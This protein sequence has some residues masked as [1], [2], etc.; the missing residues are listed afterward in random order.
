MVT[1][2]S[3]KKSDCEHYAL[4]DECDDFFK[5]K[6][7]FGKMDIYKCPFPKKKF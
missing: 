7:F 1:K 5:S 4:S 2:F 3:I 6:N